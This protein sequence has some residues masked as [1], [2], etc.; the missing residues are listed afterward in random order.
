V[1]SARKAPTSPAIISPTTTTNDVGII[2]V[3]IVVNDNANDRR[4]IIEY[5]MISMRK[6]IQFESLEPAKKLFDH[7]VVS[8]LVFTCWNRVYVNKVGLKFDLYVGI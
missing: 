4:K 6:M 3:V 8:F 2:T 5:I 7:K 1:I